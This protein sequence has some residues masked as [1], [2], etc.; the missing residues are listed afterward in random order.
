MKRLGMMILLGAA[1]AACGDGGTEGE[2]AATTGTNLTGEVLDDS[3]NRFEADGSPAVTAQT[4]PDQPS[5][6]QQVFSPSSG[7]TSIG[8]AKQLMAREVFNTDSLRKTLYCGC[9]YSVSKQI[10]AASCGFEPRKNRNG[11]VS[12]QDLIRAGRMEV[13]HVVPAAFIGTSI[14]CWDNGGRSAC[15]QNSPEY[16]KAASDLVNLRPSIGQVNR[17]RYSY[18]YGTI[19]GEA[20]VYGACDMEVDF[21]AGIAEPAPEIRGDLARITL[22]MRDRYKISMSPAYAS[23]ME[24]WARLDPVSTEE[25][26]LNRRIAQAQGHGNPRVTNAC[27]QGTIPQINLDQPPAKPTLPAI[28]ENRCGTK[29]TCKQMSSCSEAKYFLNV[30]HV[31]RLDRDGDGVP[32]ESLCK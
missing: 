24:Q 12:E 11:T 16:N 23:M 31:N 29:K 20:R 17:D 3:A 26:E 27:V 4:D 13:E 5:A 10:D 15:E 18:E 28:P 19:A 1:L 8:E 2:G 9:R 14:G 25:C 32:C 7:P 30:C 21:K 22:Y 6:V